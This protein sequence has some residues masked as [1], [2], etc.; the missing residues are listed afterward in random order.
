[1]ENKDTSK[2]NKKIAL[3]LGGVAVIWYIASMFTIWK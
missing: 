3:I 1:M 2:S